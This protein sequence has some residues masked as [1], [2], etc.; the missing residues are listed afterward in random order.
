MLW[1][2]HCPWSV[3]SG[4]LRGRE[5]ISTV[6]GMDSADHRAHRPS[7]PESPSTAYL[8]HTTAEINRKIARVK[9]DSAGP[10][11][12]ELTAYPGQVAIWDQAADRAEA[13]ET[14][15]SAL[16]L[17]L[18]DHP[19]LAFEEYHAQ[20]QISEMLQARGFVV[21]SGAH[22]VNTALRSEFTTPGFDPDRHHT[23]AIMAEYD[24]LPGIGHACGHNVIAA[25]G[26]GAFLAGVDTLR[27]QQG[28]SHPVEGRLVLLGTPA[29]EGHSG[30]EYMIR[31]GALHGVDMAI[32][33]HPFSY[34]IASHAWVGRRTLTARFQGVAA[35]ASAQPFMG[36][37]ALDA[38]SLAYQGLGLLRQQMPPSDRLHAVITEGGQRPS[39]IPQQA[40]MNIYAR[41]LLTE[42]LRDLSARIDDVLDGAA[43]MA[44]VRVH[45]EWDVHPASLPIRNNQALAARW[46]STQ[47]RRDRLALPGGVVP[48]TL[49][50]STDFGNVSQLVPA[51]HPM[52]KIAPSGV[53]LHTEE[54]ARWSRSAEAIRGAVDSAAGLAQVALDILADPVLADAARVEFESEGGAFSVAE[55]L[56]P[57]G[58]FPA[59]SEDE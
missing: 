8:D 20:R 40:S 52:V 58:Q 30:K 36:R 19:E 23:V 54:F 56:S 5:G 1:G 17:D 50:A 43:L 27:G 48:D 2:G 7:T 3:D 49:A 46:A 18:H 53:A 6:V 24:A 13:L 12:T 25:A 41:S 55:G 39:V 28:D 11:L 35:H 21:E 10:G 33:I 44:G 32:M 59:E 9:Q 47:A 34:D 31:G 4:Q 26:V 57:E 22:G 42:T 51:I 38:A 16:L 29:E 45:K 37:N 15:L 14:E